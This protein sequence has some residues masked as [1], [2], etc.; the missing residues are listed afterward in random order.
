MAH[1]LINTDDIEYTML[2]KENWITGCGVE[3]QGVWKTTIDA[4]PA[5]EA[6][7]VKV[8]E[9]KIDRY[10]RMAD[11]KHKSGDYIFSTACATVVDVLINLVKEAEN[12]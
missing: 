4:M 2:Y 3:A 6:I 11:E 5:I 1:K 10:K 8:I 12:E 7:P 9:E